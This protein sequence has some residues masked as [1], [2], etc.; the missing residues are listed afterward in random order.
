[1]LYYRLYKKMHRYFYFGSV[2]IP[3]L[4]YLTFVVFIPIGIGM[5]ISNLVYTYFSPNDA[6][7]ILALLLPMICASVYIHFCEKHDQYP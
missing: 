7:S 2:I 1:M 6:F 3:S 5:K 4:G